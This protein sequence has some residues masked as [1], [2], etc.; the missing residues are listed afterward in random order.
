[1]LRALSEAGCKSDTID[2]FTGA[3]GA[4]KLDLLGKNHGAWVRFRRVLENSLADESEVFQRADSLLQSGGSVISVFTDG[5]ESRKDCAVR[6]LK[7]HHG[8]EV[9]FWGNYTID[10][11]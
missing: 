7:T 1:M 9:T 10:R 8:Q 2:V 5:D 4:E 6:V 3:A 11:L